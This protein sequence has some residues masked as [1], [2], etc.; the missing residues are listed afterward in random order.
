MTDLPATTPVTPGHRAGNDTAAGDRIARQTL[1]DALRAAEAAAHAARCRVRTIGDLPDLVDACRLFESIWNPDGD[2]ALATPELLRAMDKAG[3]YVAAAFDATGTAADTDLAGACI[4]FFGPPPHGALHSHIAG[5]SARMRGRS[6]GFAL[7]THQRAWVLERGGTR[8]SWTFDPLVRRNAHFNI[9]KLAAR[10]AQYLTN[11]YGRMN[12][13]IN[14]ADDTDRLLV[15]WRLTAPEV[16]AAC[17]ARQADPAP[18][19]DTPSQPTATALGTGDD[20]RPVARPVRA[21]RALVAVP[22]DIERLRHSD[23][24]AAKLWRGAVREVL[25][26]LL[27]DGWQVA[28][29]DRAGRYLLVAPA[30]PSARPAHLTPKD[31]Q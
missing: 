25:G 26:G 13:G 12:D 6:I 24:R 2:N 22:E 27:A 14:G 21:R 5:V 9:R 4:G 29:F 15:E 7:K 23:P 1:A 10:P 19:A 20:G 28:G 16:A 8:V 17:H 31:P 3:S 18:A 11:F 30:A